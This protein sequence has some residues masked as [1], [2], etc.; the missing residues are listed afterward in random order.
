VPLGRSTI[1]DGVTH[2][3]YGEDRQGLDWP[4]SI[5]RSTIGPVGTHY[6]YGEGFLA[7]P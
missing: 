2:Y 1:R 4:P 5:S 3:S 7:R 6:S